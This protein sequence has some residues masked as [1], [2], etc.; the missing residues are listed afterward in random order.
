MFVRIRRTF[1]FLSALSLA[2]YFQT[3]GVGPFVTTPNKAITAI[4]LVLAAVQLVVAPRA[5]P[6]SPKNY[7]V[8]AFAVSTA[9]SMV[10]DVV[11]GIPPLGLVR[12][13]SQYAAV[14]LFY[15]VLIYVVSHRQDLDVIFW[16]L[17]LGAAFACVSGFL[18]LGETEQY[19]IYERTGGLG[20]DPNT[21]G[22]TAA[23]A[24]PMAFVLFTETRI[25]W[26]RVLLLTCILLIVAG[27][28]NTLSRSA[29]VSVAAVGVFLIWRFGR[30]D[31]LRYAPIPILLAAG[32]VFT[33]PEA[34]FAR[35]STL[36]SA[37]ARQE[38]SSIQGRLR[39]YAY[40]AQAFAS[41]PIAG[42]GFY[43]FGLWAHEN[44]DWTIG[45][46]K[47]IHSAYF[48]IAADQ[49]L[50]G[51]VPFVTI[52]IL[53]WRELSRV[54]QAA[55]RSRPSGSPDVAQLGRRA[56]FL[57]SAL[58][59]CVI[60][61]VFCPSVQ[62]KVPWLLYALSTVMIGFTRREVAALEERPGQPAAVVPQPLGVWV[63]P[64]RALRDGS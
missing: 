12:A 38:D 30:L 62:Y 63:H 46:R 24:L 51:L 29:Y 3:F 54:Q 20:G 61:N 58:L 11:A 19:S 17:T 53:T 59:A 31:L 21:L 4:L 57:Q 42:V 45:G 47:A 64:R 40:A 10:V 6:R 22:Y 9:I 50:M 44:L 35:V 7:W 48:R 15:F 26:R 37:E 36:T 18:G 28:V 33:A 34:F 55:R 52:I 16:G 27:I 41:N 2:Q 5:L 56:L 1:L 13:G 32:L 60:G 49:G 14:I 23:A 43:R 8:V 25:L 39:D